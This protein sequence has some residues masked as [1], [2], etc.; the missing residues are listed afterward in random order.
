MVRRRV[1]IV[2]WVFSW[3]VYLSSNYHYGLLVVLSSCLGTNLN[4]FFL[5]VTKITPSCCSFGYGEQGCSFLEI[6]IPQPTYIQSSRCCRK[7]GM[8]FPVVPKRFHTTSSE[9]YHRYLCLFLENLVAWLEHSRV[10]LMS[11]TASPNF[12]TFD[13]S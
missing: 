5:R 7:S 3:L 1:S 13:Y 2:H 6:G 10:N 8:V 4:F 9:S 11:I 12:Q